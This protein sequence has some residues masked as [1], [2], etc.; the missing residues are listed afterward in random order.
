MNAEEVAKL[1]AALNLKERGGPMMP[2]QGNLKEVRAKR[3][4]LR[5]V[6]KILSNKSLEDRH[7]VLQGGPW[8]FDKALL[9]IQEPEVGDCLEKVDKR[10]REDHNLLF[11]SCLSASSMIK[12]DPSQNRN[13]VHRGGGENSG[14]ETLVNDRV[15][16]EFGD[17]MDCDGFDNTVIC[18]NVDSGMHGKTVV[19]GI[20]D[21]INHDIVRLIVQLLEYWK[22]DHC[23]ILLEVSQVYRLVGDGEPVVANSLLHGVESELL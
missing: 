22:S 23:P 15:G 19:H 5:F 17:I 4:A 18:G 9:V 1:C 20:N 12:G 11:G 21:D 14:L 13:E 10:S 6:E 7:M 3:L 16:P 2:L 8:S